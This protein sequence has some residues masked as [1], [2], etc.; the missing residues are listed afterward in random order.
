[1]TDPGDQRGVDPA[2]W[3]SWNWSPPAPRDGRPTTPLWT[4]S[5]VPMAWG[6]P[7]EPTSGPVAREGWP[8]S[9]PR[10]APD[11]PG[12]PAWRTFGAPPRRAGPSWPGVIAVAATTAL[13]GAI[14][15]GALGAALIDPGRA[16][17][18]GPALTPGPGATERPAGSLAAVAANALPSVVTIRS[19]SATGTATGSGFVFDHDGHVLT[20]NHVVAAVG[21][22]I[23]VVLGDGTRLDATVVG[24][25]PAYDVAVLAT[26]RADLPPL[27]LG[28][29]G[30]VV[31]GDEVIAVGAPL[32][33]SSTVTSG[34][35]SAL[36][37]PVVAGESSG[38]S[39]INAIQTDAAINPGNSGGP[40][41]DLSGRVIGMNS[42]I[43]QPPGV[44]RGAGN[45]G[46]GFAIPSDQLAKTAAQLLDHGTASHPVIGVLLDLDYA[47][48]GARVQDES[49]TGD[50][51]TA[52]G[53]AER[54]GVEPGD[55][56][57]AFDGRAVADSDDLIVA[58]RAKDVGDRVHVS[59]R[60][61]GKLVD[62]TMTLQ[63][64]PA[65]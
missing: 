2:R 26:S 28:D 33:L 32:G 11:A 20:N 50:P 37:R 42:A 40:L 57:V 19:G 16:D 30:S 24:T 47:G 49:A 34:I 61:D 21:T 6:D 15:G 1:M 22:S 25:D 14:L 17:R 59:L 52:G 18:P 64:A 41:L 38:R 13:L 53:P 58:I 55:V 27:P 35:V 7:A 3:D 10:V 46:L 39:Y 36:N 8:A 23:V 44:T 63:A 4:P 48:P 29:P 54:A 65:K 31:V 51:V 5:P 62:V 43:A 60:R 45:I 12:T 56:I 9:G